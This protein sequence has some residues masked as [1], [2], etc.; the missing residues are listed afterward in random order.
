MEVYFYHSKAR[1]RGDGYILVKALIMWFFSYFKKR[2]KS[3]TNLDI[4]LKKTKFN[5]KYPNLV[6]LFENKYNYFVF[7]GSYGD[8]WLILSLLYAHLE[9]YKNTIVL[10]SYSD[11]ELVRIFIN[12]KRI[13]RNFVFLDQEVINFLSSCFRPQGEFSTQIIDAYSHKKCYH[14][15]TPFLLKNGLPSGTIRHLHLVYYPYFN[16]LINIHGVSY[17]AL[18]KIILYLPYNIKP[19]NPQY[20]RKKDVDAARKL[21]NSP[22]NQSKKEIRKLILF[23]IVNFSQEQLLARHI[24]LISKICILYGFKVLIN[25]AQI[26]KSSLG[27]NE[28]KKNLYSPSVQYINIPPHLLS[29]VCNKVY[30][31]IGVLGG[32]MSVA[33]QFSNAHILSLHTPSLGLG[34]QENYLFGIW[35]KERL[36]EWINQDWPCI[37]KGRVII[38]KFVGDPEA[39]QM[40]RLSNIVISFIQKCKKSSLV[41]K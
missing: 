17:A 8:K 33:V 10:A 29:L 5:K 39:L 34:V 11:Q 21:I 12:A 41:K 1:C 28:I 4:F 9:R 3:Q 37:F 26:E 19:K 30:A 16:E 6:N 25:I 36:W 32:A 31:V 20:F 24:K 14:T 22:Q 15:I 27:L 23:N 35:N 18:Q 13:K 38:N 7:Q 2:K 40:Q